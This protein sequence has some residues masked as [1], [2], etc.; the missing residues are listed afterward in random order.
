MSICFTLSVSERAYA[1]PN[2]TLTKFIV[3]FQCCRC[4]FCLRLYN[5]KIILYIF[6]LFY[7]SETSRMTCQQFTRKKEGNSNCC[8]GWAVI[9]S[10][11]WIKI[12]SDWPLK[13]QPLASRPFLLHSQKRLHPFKTAENAEHLIVF[14]YSWNRKCYIHIRHSHIVNVVGE[15]WLGWL[16]GF[17]NQGSETKPFNLTSQLELSLYSSDNSK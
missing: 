5:F 3:L 2:F 16:V 8:L 1:Q 14:V 15:G 11:G 17:H 7:F 10:K 9:R 13:I 12:C 4:Y 6:D